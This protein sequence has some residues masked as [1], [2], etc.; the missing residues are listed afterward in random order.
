MNVEICHKVKY[1]KKDALTMLNILKEGKGRYLLSG[2]RRK[3]KHRPFKIY[4][5][6]ICNCWH[7]TS[8]IPYYMTEN[9]INDT[10]ER[11]ISVENNKDLDEILTNYDVLLYSNKTC[12]RC[13]VIYD[14]LVAKGFEKVIRLKI[15]HSS[16]YPSFPK[17]K[18][19]PIIFYKGQEILTR[20]TDDIIREF[21]IIDRKLKD[22]ARDNQ[23]S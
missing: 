13:K 15:T 1:K 14:S 6:N 22:N 20:K 21:N 5:C 8:K 2:K 3:T 11:L 7:L 19:L 18:S 23:I 17:F 4:H 16:V 12:Y 10:W 9:K